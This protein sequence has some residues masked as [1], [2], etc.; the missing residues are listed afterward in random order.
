MLGSSPNRTQD[1][2]VS[3]VNIKIQVFN[4]TYIFLWD[5]AIG[6][7]A[8]VIGNAL[9]DSKNRALIS[10]W[11][12]LELT[13]IPYCTEWR[14]LLTAVVAWKKML[15]RTFPGKTVLYKSRC[16]GSL[17]RECRLT[18]RIFCAILAPGLLKSLRWVLVSKSL[19][20]WCLWII[21]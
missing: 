6:L 13:D 2:K 21:L 3:L 10:L 12:K 5:K 17:L 15:K 11:H 8:F 9:K 7:S 4:I 18:L 20:I 16:T 14:G 19:Y 1:I